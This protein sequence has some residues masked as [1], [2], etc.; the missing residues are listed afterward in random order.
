[1]LRK[2]NRVESIR[3]AEIDAPSF[4]VGAPTANMLGMYPEFWK[5]GVTMLERSRFAD[6]MPEEVEA[7][8]EKE[9]E[10]GL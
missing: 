7:W 2:I 6:V 1:M 10:V 3:S 8:L 4:M 9:F 5:S